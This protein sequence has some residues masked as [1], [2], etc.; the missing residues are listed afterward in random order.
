MKLNNREK[1]LLLFALA[2][3]LTVS[4]VKWGILPAI[5]YKRTFAV[6]YMKKEKQ[7]QKTSMLLRNGQKYQHKLREEIA[8]LEELKSFTFSGKEIQVQLKLLETVDGFLKESG[9]EITDKKIEVEESETDNLK[10]V[11]YILSLN[12]KLEH[13]VNLLESLNN[14][15]KFLIVDKLIIRK[16]QASRYNDLKVNLRIKAINIIDEEIDNDGEEKE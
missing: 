3:M 8:K 12:G 2:V 6:T 13:L 5:R 16:G 4:I 14:A 7:W 11:Y 1:R 15:N 9:L 10:I